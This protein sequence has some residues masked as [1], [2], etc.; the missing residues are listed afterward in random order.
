MKFHLIELAAE[1]AASF[2]SHR[3]RGW[4]FEPLTAILENR[5]KV[6]ELCGNL[7]DDG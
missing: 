4:A 2:L 5:G 3:N 6:T 1:E 7:G